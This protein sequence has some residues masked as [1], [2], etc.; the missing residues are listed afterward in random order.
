MFLRLAFSRRLLQERILVILAFLIGAIASKDYLYLLGLGDISRLLV[1]V[2][3]MLL[4]LGLLIS[5]SDKGVS[6]F[7][8]FHRFIIFVA[9]LIVLKYLMLCFESPDMVF[10]GSSSKFTSSAFVYEQVS[11]FED[12]YYLF[13]ALTSMYLAVRWINTFQAYL[14]TVFA[15]L[16]GSA[17]APAIGLIFFSYNIG[18]RV[19]VVDGVNFAGGFWNSSVIGFTSVYWLAFTLQRKGFYKKWLVLS[20]A[21]LLLFGALFG[22]SRSIFVAFGI[23]GLVYCWN[24]KSAMK[25]LLFIS[26]FIIVA[27][28]FVY[29]FSSVFTLL[30]GRMGRTVL[31]DELR[32]VIWGE[33]LEHFLEYGLFGCSVLGYKH[34]STGG[35]GPHSIFINWMVHFGVLGLG[36]F[37][38]LL[39]LVHQALHQIRKNLSSDI[40]AAVLAWLVSYLCLVSWDETGFTTVSFYL[41]IGLV[42]ALGKVCHQVRGSV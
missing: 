12:M 24:I 28:V 39:W 16:C 27:G 36:V 7:L 10:G 38:Y 9:G 6:D 21:F 34:Y 41:A 40:Y 22:L 14:K 31:S 18:S 42:L 19:V 5:W 23:A 4:G 33:Y 32:V 25:K 30:Q 1:F 37:T 2:I 29:Y 3:L 11:W 17:L 8:G 15:L 35:Y 26:L 20:L 13:M